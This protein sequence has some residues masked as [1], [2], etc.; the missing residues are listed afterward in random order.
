MDWEKEGGAAPSPNPPAELKGDTGVWG[1]R[2]GV[3]R[4]GADGKLEADANR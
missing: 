1:K 2:E 3:K 4:G